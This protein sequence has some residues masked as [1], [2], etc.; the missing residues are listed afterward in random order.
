MLTWCV[1]TAAATALY[2]ATMAPGVLWGD[3]GEAQIRV[4]AGSLA[5]FD[6]LVRAHVTYYLVA[7]GIHRA[8]NLEAA[9]A[10]NLVSALAGAITVG[11]FAVLASLLVR[12]RISVLCATS[13]LML[14]HTLWQ[15]SAGAEV[16]TF[17]TMLLTAELVML[18]R[19]VT[20]GSRR[21]LAL[22]ALLNGLGLATH[23][24]ALL[25]WP[26]YAWAL[27]RAARSGS[28]P[29][30][31][32]IAG[33]LVAWT[34]GV[35]PLAVL[36]IAHLRT[37]GSIAA[38]MTSLLTG[39]FERQVFNTQL[40]GGTLLRNAGMLVLN[41]PTPLVLLAI[42][43]WWRCRTVHR[44]LWSVLTIAFAVYVLFAA[45]YRVP[46]QYT[47]MVHSY[48][49]VA[50]F[51]A[52]GIDI[53]TA[54]IRSRWALVALVVLSVWSPAAYAAMPVFARRYAGS[55][56]PIPARD[57]PHRDTYNWFLRPWRLGDHGPERFAREM[58]QD[59]P[60]S[61]VVIMDATLRHPVDYLQ[62]RDRLRLDVRLSNAPTRW[63][64]REPINVT[65]DTACDW[66]S[67]GLLFV[68]S[69]VPSYAPNWILDGEYGFEPFGHLYQ[70]HSV[71]CGLGRRQP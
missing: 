67:R 15:L 47:F 37:S 19:F 44:D 66:I 62:G 22:A 4:L 54:R 53:V 49:F 55:L 57:V 36:T 18:V 35:A 63:N 27:W 64:S 56:M 20:T 11:N 69:T 17:S 31:R 16:V 39:G 41:F 28:R 58:L 32:W 7:I 60:E 70:V 71:Q 1:A 33:S 59:L 34:V 43:G 29:S 14:S 25:I 40:S 12:S 8:F 68:S 65:A 24:F 26:A 6:E 50:L 30:A 46:D 10:A 2:V 51:V 13:M 5:G 48:V 52:L 45:R 38:T 3:A 61:A 42:W 23:N 21:W 9:V